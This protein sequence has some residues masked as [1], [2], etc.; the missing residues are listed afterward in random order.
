MATAICIARH[1]MLMHPRLDL[2]PFLFDSQNYYMDCIR[3][4]G[5]HIFFAGAAGSIAR[6]K[7]SPGPENYSGGSPFTTLLYVYVYIC[8]FLPRYLGP[9]SAFTVFLM[10]AG[11][12][13]RWQT[14]KRSARWA[15][16]I[17][18]ATL[19]FMKAGI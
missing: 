3:M 4:D 11:N 18:N 2:R 10:G 7:L 15:L 17:Q 13:F 8:S 1:F 12:I 9:L 19:I 6:R 16:W 14:N 5:N